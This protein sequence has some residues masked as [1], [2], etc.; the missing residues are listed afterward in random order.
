MVLFQAIRLSQSHNQINKGTLQA[1]TLICQ[2]TANSEFKGYQD[3]TIQELIIK[4]HNIRYRL[5]LWKTPSGE[6]LRGELAGELR[7][8]GHFGKMLK[9]YI[10]YQYYHCHVTQPLLLEQL[11]EWE[12]DIS[13]GQL[14]KIIVEEKEKYHP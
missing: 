7:E 12:I 4:P 1:I 5:A 9:T 13:A 10:L 3:Y 2:L 6:T 14:S 8:Q 11:R